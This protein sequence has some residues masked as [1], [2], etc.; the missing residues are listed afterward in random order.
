MAH[1]ANT[2]IEFQAIAIRQ[3]NSCSGFT[4]NTYNPWKLVGGAKGRE[5]LLVRIV[6][7]R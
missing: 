6:Y 5:D 7:E 1:Y 2:E 3:Q 4:I